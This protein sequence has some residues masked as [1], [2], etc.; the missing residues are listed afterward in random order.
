MPH[1]VKYD[2]AFNITKNNK[3]IT[4]Y[5]KIV[6][7]SFKATKY[8]ASYAKAGQ[9]IKP[10]RPM[11]TGKILGITIHNTGDITNTLAGIKSAAEQYV[12]A[13]YNCNMGGS[14][15]HYYVSNGV[16][17]QLL[18]DNEQ[19]WHSGTANAT[20]IGKRG[21]LIGGNVDTIAIEC[22]GASS[23]AEETTAVLTAWLCE[24]HGLDPT[25]D[26]YTHKDWSG[27]QCP[28]Y[29]LPH[30]NKFIETVK[31]YIG[32]SVAT[33]K[34]TPTPAPAPTPTTP[35]KPTVA[36]EEGDKVRVINTTKSGSRTYGKLYG[37]G[38][39]TVYYDKYDVIGKPIGNRVVIGIGK[40]VTAAVNIND[41][42]KM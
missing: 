26:I 9:P 29:I 4:V 39:F 10:C 19:G 33:P 12:L 13:T 38:T 42:Q 24:K 32:N 28:L 6:P 37:G 34:P 30:W 16:V 20:K 14:I 27:K 41:L 7:D 21:T 8:V 36:I 25:L 23:G 3:T 35:Q 15:V 17:W 22:V 40:T 5:Q 1:S 11:R 31:G 18:N 2:K